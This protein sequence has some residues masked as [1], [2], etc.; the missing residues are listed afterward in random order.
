V[1]EKA[2][3]FKA[4]I[5]LADMDRDYYGDFNLTIALHPSETIERMLVR[6]LAFC[7]CAAENLSFTRG[8]S[9]VDEPDLWL[10]H[11]DGRIL[12]WVEVGQP[13]PDRLKKASGQSQSVRVFAYGRGLDIWWKGNAAAI[14]SLSKVTIHYFAADELQAASQTIEK[15]M[16]LSVTITEGMVYLSAGDKTYT[17]TLQSM[18]SLH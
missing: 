2:T 13:A 3:I 16:S 1:A 7:Y 17:L 6:I 4:N 10:K 9:S 11:D 5:Q 15:T 12:E 14:T 8:L 18:D